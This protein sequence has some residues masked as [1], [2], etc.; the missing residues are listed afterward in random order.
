MGESIGY[1]VLRQASQCPRHEPAVRQTHHAKAKRST[2]KSPSL[3][4]E[5]TKI[6]MTDKNKVPIRHVH[7]CRRTAIVPSRSPCIDLALGDGS[8]MVYRS[9]TSRN[10]GA[11]AGTGCDVRAIIST[12]C[13]PSNTRHYMVAA[14][15]LVHNCCGRQDGAELPADLCCNRCRSQL[16]DLTN[17][18]QISR[19]GSQ[20]RLPGHTTCIP[21]IALASRL[22]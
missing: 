19:V 5:G 4:S 21:F 14:P 16:L 22:C 20:E 6:S 11:G 13:P 3:Q 12:V 1:A 18:V 17:C 2:Q 7:Y 8:A 9:A 10:Q 15:K